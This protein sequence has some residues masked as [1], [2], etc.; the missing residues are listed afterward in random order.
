MEGF[1]KIYQ[2]ETLEDQE[3]FISEIE[4]LYP[5]ASWLKTI[6]KAS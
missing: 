1:T 3:A 2:F 5:Q 6:D 4:V